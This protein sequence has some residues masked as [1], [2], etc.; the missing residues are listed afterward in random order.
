MTVSCVFLKIG[1]TEKPSQ[2][3]GL[4]SKLVKGLVVRE[5]NFL[6]KVDHRASVHM[7]NKFRCSQTEENYAC[8]LTVARVRDEVNC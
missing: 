7:Q 6:I 2:E 4:K 8:R 3:F 1:R 5:E